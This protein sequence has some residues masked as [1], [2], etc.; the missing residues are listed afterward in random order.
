MTVSAVVAVAKNGVIGRE[1]EIPWRLPDDLKHFAQT[2][3]GHTVIMGRKTFEAIADTLGGPLPGRQNIV[4]TRNPGV[5]YDGATVVNT[6]DDALAKAESS[7]EVFIIGGGEIYK[8]ALP[9]TDKIYLTEVDT[10]V[11]GDTYFPRLDPAEWTERGREEF[12]ADDRN[13]YPFVIKVLERN[14]R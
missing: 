10:E 12:A 4:I 13:E 7:D 1:R 6:L 5:S 11:E 3:K 2:T 14:E 8:L 9:Q